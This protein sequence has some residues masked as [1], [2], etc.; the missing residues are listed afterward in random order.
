[1]LY[2]VSKDEL[3][4]IIPLTLTLN[5]FSFKLFNYKNYFVML[6]GGGSRRNE[7][8]IGGMKLIGPPCVSLQKR[9]C[10]LIA[11]SYLISHYI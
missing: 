10:S 4:L 11:T 3:K 8:L 7:R 1:M 5:H 9:L 6:Q 2:G